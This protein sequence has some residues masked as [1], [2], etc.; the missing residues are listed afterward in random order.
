VECVAC[1]QSNHF[2]LNVEIDPHRPGLSLW[3]L[4]TIC[5]CTGCFR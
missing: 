2:I 4:S 5:N 3:C 1:L